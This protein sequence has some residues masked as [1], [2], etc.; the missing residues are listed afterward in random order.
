[1][2]TNRTEKLVWD[3]FCKSVVDA[4]GY[5]YTA[6]CARRFVKLEQAAKRRATWTKFRK[7][8]RRRRAERKKKNAKL[9]KHFGELKINGEWV[10][11]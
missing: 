9:P 7:L 2:S 1:M 3:C 11:F 5:T 10:K 4:L 6:K 8:C